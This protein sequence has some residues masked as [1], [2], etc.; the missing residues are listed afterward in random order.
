MQNCTT[1]DNIWACAVWMTSCKMCLHEE[2]RLVKWVLHLFRWWTKEKILPVV[3]T[4]HCETINHVYLAIF[5]TI[6]THLSTSIAAEIFKLLSC[7]CTPA[8]RGFLW[9]V[10]R[11]LSGKASTSKSDWGNSRWRFLFES[12]RGRMLKSGMNRSL[13]KH[14]TSPIFMRSYRLSGSGSQT[15]FPWRRRISSFRYRH[16]WSMALMAGGVAWEEEEI[17]NAGWQENFERWTLLYSCQTT[18]SRLCLLH[19]LAPYSHTTSIIVVRS[20]FEASSSS[21]A[22]VW[23]TWS[24][25]HRLLCLSLALPVIIRLEYGPIHSPHL[26][27][28]N[29]SVNPANM[30]DLHMSTKFH[31]HL[32]CCQTRSGGQ[33]WVRAMVHS[34]YYSVSTR[35]C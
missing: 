22:S 33:L 6:N 12:S 27:M 15:G 25:E 24:L 14:P 10:V 8:C 34:V 5:M 30:A 9:W 21:H 20:C 17:E 4:Q 13:S 26:L 1:R 31:L 35:Q 29:S 19:R 7:P 23:T 18:S 11:T 2:L 3:P 28:R 16:A 32:E